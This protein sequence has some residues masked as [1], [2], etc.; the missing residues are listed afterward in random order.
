MFLKRTLF[1]KI[2]LCQVTVL[3]VSVSVGVDTDNLSARAISNMSALD[4]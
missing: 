3:V 2:R 1:Q 4:S